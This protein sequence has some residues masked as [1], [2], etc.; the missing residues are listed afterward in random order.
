KKQ[1]KELLKRLRQSDPESLDRVTASHLKP[2]G[3]VGE[4]QRFALADAQLVIAREHGQ[5]TWA[6]FV[7]EIARVT[8]QR[9]AEAKGVDYA[10]IVAASVPRE[11][12]HASGDLTA[13]NE[14]LRQNPNLASQNIYAAS[15]LGDVAAVRRFLA[16]DSSL[17]TAE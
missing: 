15:V 1:A 7:H 3:G 11:G 9:L 5:S 4:E 14:L 16:S 6:D 13:A 2:P 17:A 12:W 8:S 10:F